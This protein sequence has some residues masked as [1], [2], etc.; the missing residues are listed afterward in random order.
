MSA[1]MTT[2][3][4]NTQD[5][6]TEETHMDCAVILLASGQSLRF[7]PSHKLLALLSGQAVIDHVIKNLMAVPFAARF[8]VVPPSQPNHAADDISE[9]KRAQINQMRQILERAHYHLIDNLTPETGQGAA[10][11]LGVKRVL[12]A[13]HERACIALSDMPL[14]PSAHFQALLNLSKDCDQ[15]VS[16]SDD[17]GRSITLPPCI[18]TG[19]ALRR[20]QLLHGDYGA[21]K[22][23]MGQDVLRCRLEPH[24]AIDIDRLDDLHKAQDYINAEIT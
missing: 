18:F 6:P 17:N 7:E 4:K 10:L 5:T 21:R 23:L 9:P 8:A 20:L 22:Y 11:A 13:G 14:V 3:S 15:I 12:A 16:Q 1:N 24:Q 19:E 2:I